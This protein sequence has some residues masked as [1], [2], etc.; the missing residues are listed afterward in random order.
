MVDPNTLSLDALFQHLTADGSL[1]RVIDAAIDEDLGGVGDVT[2]ESIIEPM[3]SGEANLVPRA[4]GVVAGLAVLLAI[5]E[6]PGIDASVQSFAQDGSRCQPGEVLARLHGRF[7]HILTLERTILNLIGHLSGIATH[8]AQFVDA[9]KG[10]RAVICE[11]RKTTP[12]LRGLEKYAVRCGGATLHRFGLHDAALFK[13]NHL[14]HLNVDQFA[15]ALAAAAKSARQ[16]HDLRFVEV[17]VDTL[18]QLQQVLT[19]DQGLIDIV[20]LDNMSPDLLR[21]AIQQRDQHQPNLLLEASGSITLDNV[22][23]IAETG[24]DRIAIGSITHSAPALDIG[25]D[26]QT[27]QDPNAMLASKAT[28][29]E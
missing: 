10:T 18:N 21:Q 26:V 1:Q 20:L 12:G 6:Q 8:T 19:L 3:R 15:S 14:A 9:V 7:A 5:L 13:D 2:T 27:T 24:V 11:T 4:D 23:E 22:R 16:R 29:A 25:L 17:E 28:P